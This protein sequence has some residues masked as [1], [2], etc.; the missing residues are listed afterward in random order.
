MKKRTKKIIGL[1]LA[2]ALCMTF[3]PASVFATEYGTGSTDTELAMEVDSP[4]VTVSYHYFDASQNQGISDVED[5]TIQSSHSY[6]VIAM[7][8]GDTV[9]IAANK[10]PSVIPV[11]TDT[12]RFRVVLNAGQ[13]EEMDITNEATYDAATG[14]LTLPS[15]Y[16]TQR[17]DVSWYC[18]SSEI[19]E[20]PVKVSVCEYQNGEYT[21]TEHDL[22]LAS[23][24][25]SVSVPVSVSEAIVVAQNS[26]DL[27]TNQYSVEDGTLTISAAALGAD[28]SVSAYA[29]VKTTMSPMSEGISLM[30]TK[31][32][33]NHS[34]SSS[35]IYY[36]YFTSRYSADG[37]TAFCLNTDMSGVN[38]G[39]YDISGWLIPGSSEKNDN[40]IKC[41]Y[42]LFGPA[43]DS[44]KTNLFE[45]PDSDYAYGLSHAVAAYVW[46]E[47]HSAFGGLSSTVI[48]HLLRVLESVKAQPMPPA[49]FNAFLYN[50]GNSQ[51][52]SLLSWENNP[53]WNLNLQKKSN[54]PSFTDNND[55]YSLEGA[56]FKLYDSSDV[57]QGTITTDNDGK[58]SLADIPY[59]TG[60]GF[61][62]LETKSPQGYA[63]NTAKIP[64]NG[65]TAGQTI[66]I[67]VKN[68]PQ[69]DPAVIVLQKVDE[70]T[71]EPVPEGDASLAGAIFVVEYYQ[72]LYD[73]ESDLNGLTP[74]RKW[75]L[76]TSA[77][78]VAR[79]RDGD[80]VGGDPFYY[81]ST[82]KIITIPLGTVKIYEQT[83]P[84][85]YKKNPTVYIRQIKAKGKMEFVDTYSYPE[86]PEPVKKGGVTTLKLDDWLLR[87]GQPQGSATL[88]EATFSIRN[89][90]KNPVEVAGKIYQPNEIVYTGK[91]DTDGRFSTP[92]AN[93]LPVGRYRIEEP[94]GGA[95]TGYLGEGK[96]TQ[97]FDI[98]DDG[99]M[100]DL[101][102]KEN[103]IANSVKRGSVVVE[104]WDAEI[105]RNES[106][107][108]GTLDEAVFWLYNRNTNPVVVDDVEYAPGDVV[109]T[110]ETKDGFVATPDRFLPVGTYEIVETS[111]PREGYLAIGTLNRTFTLTE[112][113]QV[114]YMTTTSTAI[115]NFPVRGDVQGLK[116]SDADGKR[117]ANI[118]FEIR[119]LTT[120]EA[121]VIVTDKNGEFNTSSDWVP[122]SQNTNRGQTSED[123]V[124]FGE[125]WALSDDVGGLLY[126][127]Y[128][129]TELPCENNEERI[130]LSFEFSLTKHGYT[131]QLGTLTNDLEPTIELFTTARDAD[132]TTNEA[133]VSEMTT[134]YDTAYYSGLPSGNYVLR[135]HLVDYETG[136]ILK[137]D[138]QPVTSEHKFRASGNGNVT[139]A[140]KF[141]SLDLAGRAVVVYQVLEDDKGNTLASHCD[142][143]SEEQRISFREP[144]IST[145]LTGAESEKEVDVL[146]EIIL[147]DEARF[148]NVVVGQTYVMSG[149]LVEQTTGEP[150]L[151]NGKEVT[152]VKEFEAKTESGVISMEFKFST[153]SLAG[154]T[155][156]AFESMTHNG[157][158][159][160]VHKDLES[161]A[162][163]VKVKTP[164]V[165]GTSAA[166]AEGNKQLPTAEKVTI[167][168]TM[169][170]R[171]LAPGVEH[172][173]KG[174][175]MNPE[176]G[177]VLFINGKPVTGEQLFV[178][179]ETGAGT[180]EV[181]FELDSRSLDQKTVVVFE[182]LHLVGHD[183]PLSVHKDITDEAQAVFFAAK[184][185][186]I[187]TSATAEDGSKTVPIGE[188][189]KVIDRATYENLFVGE[190]YVFHGTVMDKESGQALKNGD[191]PIISS[192]VFVP[193][194]PN[195]T[196]D[197]I[198]EF[199]S[200]ELEG[201][202]LVVFEELE[203]REKIIA[204][205]QDL[206]DTAQTVQVLKTDIPVVHTP[207]TG[208]DGNM[209][210]WI[211][212]L[213]ASIAAMVIVWRINKKLKTDRESTKQQ[214]TE[215]DV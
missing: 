186:N 36:G 103:A 203:Y 11:S 47:N 94:S 42:Y 130:L 13:P 28:L 20:I 48:D 14:Q 107:G 2:I 148:D 195:G 109:A 140:F 1:L 153:L 82:G 189:V 118:P 147:I 156:V 24:L 194:T 207:K 18:L 122:H 23:N 120:D 98:T 136:D 77:Q 25:S 44:V 175:L 155:I 3:T 154:K 115:K 150:I 35:Q 60:T 105:D 176:D 40:L 49:G 158:E 125:L 121:H 143:A 139:V 6:H 59:G 108:K 30:S 182:E 113:G 78:G 145:M 162:Q 97:E 212:L 72:G 43:Y 151:D 168:D 133:Y 52:Q 177:Y 90:S 85:S 16:L 181:V 199:D 38:S 178:P 56:E 81:D 137:R 66:E 126:D 213:I 152:C 54:N 15:A 68:I 138:E 127:D 91:T 157:K 144:L 202:T 87:P 71:G 86:V 89:I 170:Y 184:P 193:E 183:E 76:K 9:T 135:G 5:Y 174:V 124:W 149:I 110:L 70:F 80:K 173:A 46:M 102:A 32:T 12:L 172:L 27:H 159:V 129:I 134:I 123:G 67:E 190:E 117:M 57:L 166:D 75:L 165:I 63:D 50:V 112:D 33:V 141:N 19:T 92:N 95:P 7:A 31:T 201:R 99:M 187:K 21:T 211:M 214:V 104:K 128:V 119:S 17:I 22:S 55:C 114:E 101:T 62:L 39:V 206:Q 106:Q 198:F 58:G 197:I 93:Y 29:P 171:G 161:E 53:V 88:R 188:N 10:Y 116:I 164:L 160:A 208:D 74:V 73:K 84:E 111:P 4:L 167:I 96:L 132:T 209:G 200:R 205:H 65:V 61:Y 163:S 196:V 79:L 45:N 64:V 210:L 192:T 142:L 146:K 41:A 34:R 26:I 100:V 131:I 191:H 185:I 83:P 8:D 169:T 204:V 180:V 69:G 215:G 179:D 51:S 37:N